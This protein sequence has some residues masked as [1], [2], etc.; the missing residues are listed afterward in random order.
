MEK[1][2]R[3][4]VE[5]L[6]RNGHEALL[7][8]G[9][10][11]D[12][13]LGRP[14][15]DIDI[16]TSARPDQVLALFPHSTPIGA[17]FGVVKVRVFRCAFE[18]ATFRTEGPYIDGRH[19]SSVAFA[20]ARQDA[21]RRDFTVNGLFYDPVADR[22]LDFVGGRADLRRRVLR[23]IGPPR[24]RFAEDHLRVLR[25]V[26]LACSLGF[27]IETRTWQAVRK[28]AP[29]ITS[30]SAERVRDELLKLLRGPDPE[31]GLTLL[32]ESGLLA[33]IL[34]ELR[35]TLLRQRTGERA[36][37][38]AMAAKALGLLR[39][40]SPALVL[41]TLLLP[42]GE[43][44]AERICRRL[45]LPNSTVRAVRSLIAANAQLGDA[46]NIR[47]SR[48]KRILMSPEGPEHLELLRV[49]CLAAGR[50]LDDYRW[51]V[52]T[53]RDIRREI[54]ADPLL[55]GQDLIDLGYKPGPR[56]REILEAVEDL[57]LEHSLRSRR[58]ALEYVTRVYPGN[59]EQAHE[60]GK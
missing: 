29:A 47:Q 32:R 2:A 8:G 58:E 17:S 41:A 11:R 38:S 27:R 4:I 43:D 18:V 46:R 34:P 49:W 21:L 59:P 24:R 25:A 30:V 60:G 19:P 6:R 28:L 9:W 5:K 3:R 23:A 35:P 48:L 15:D 42:A 53:V 26:R 16:A 50:G 12:R 51:C 1:A 45:R 13:L 44:A 31:R 10:V 56:F 57:R 52:R 20:D 33:R 39:K 36:D 40:S 7:A 22:I 55:T 54:S 37:I 14:S